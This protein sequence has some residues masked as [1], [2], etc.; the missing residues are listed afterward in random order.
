MTTRTLAT[1]IR[2]NNKKEIELFQKIFH[3]PEKLEKPLSPK[4][5]IG[6]YES[7]YN[8]E[9]KNSDPKS[10]S[11]DELNL[12]RSIKDNFKKIPKVKTPFIVK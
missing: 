11:S 7:S 2:N 5:T 9:P 6:I 8:N 4:Q 3:A 10:N 12:T 1:V